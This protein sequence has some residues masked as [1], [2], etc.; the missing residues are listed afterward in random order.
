MLTSVNDQVYL[1]LWYRELAGKPLY[2]YDLRLVR[3]T[4]YPI[5][6]L[7][8]YTPRGKPP[9]AGKHWSAEPT[10]GFGQRAR[11]RVP[12]AE[13]FTAL[14]IRWVVTRDTWLVTRDT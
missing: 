8:M 10:F 1:V 6:I 13:T 5:I 2:S 4:S 11:F 7:T 14:V 3:Q 9:Q 12:A